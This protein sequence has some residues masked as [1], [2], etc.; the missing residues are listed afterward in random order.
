MLFVVIGAAAIPKISSNNSSSSSS[1]SRSKCEI[2]DDRISSVVPA[3]VSV[4][5]ADTAPYIFTVN[6]YGFGSVFS[7]S[8]AEPGR[9]CRAAAEGVKANLFFSNS[10]Q[11]QLQ[12]LNNDG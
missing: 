3:E 7:P 6:L 5:L 4:A 8:S 1:S 9:R 11:L 10:L 12:L 2:S